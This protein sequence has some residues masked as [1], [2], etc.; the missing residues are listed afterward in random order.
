MH[1][2]RVPDPAA[3]AIAAEIA[4]IDGIVA[5]LRED[6]SDITDRDVNVLKEVVQSHLNLAIPLNDEN[7]KKALQW[8]PDMITL[9]PAGREESKASCLDVV[10]NQEYLEDV[11]A[12]LRANNIVVSVLIE[13][14]AKQIRA[15]ARLRVDYVQFNTHHLSR[16]EDLG[17]MGEHV[18]H[19]RSATMAASKL[20]LGVSVGRGLGYQNIRE[21]S[22]ISS[23]EEIN[24]GAA[25]VA[26]SMLVGL[27]RALENLKSLLEA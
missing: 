1:K 13:V 25:I 27:E 6:R 19:L 20:G 24:I 3:I 5:Y 15:A 23:I 12:A 10:G 9:L 18:E 14:D 7:V 4:G 16:I 26:R 2:D 21:I 22:D 17:T 11:V 8:L